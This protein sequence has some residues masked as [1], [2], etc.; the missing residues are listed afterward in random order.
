MHARNCSNQSTPVCRRLLTIFKIA[1]I[2]QLKY[3][4]PYRI[5][6]IKSRKFSEIMF[7]RTQSG[8]VQL[9]KPRNLFS[10]S[11]IIINTKGSESIYA[12]KRNDE[13]QH[14][15]LPA[16]SIQEIQ[17]KAREM[18]NRKRVR[19]PRNPPF[20]LLCIGAECRVYHLSRDVL[21]RARGLQR[22]HVFE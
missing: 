4:V 8:T 19:Y 14:H 11:P 1:L 22:S 21:S 18:H 20:I 10:L 17:N 15:P 7:L 12:K 2:S 5:T 3:A 13:Q 16:F 9:L 6:N